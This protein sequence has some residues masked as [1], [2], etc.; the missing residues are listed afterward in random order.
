VRRALLPGLL[1]VV[2]AGCGTTANLHLPEDV[3]VSGPPRMGV[4]GGVSNSVAAAK[5][6]ASRD[7]LRPKCLAALA[8]LDV[9]LSAIGDTLTLPLTAT[10]TAWRLY[11]ES[12]PKPTPPPANDTPEPLTPERIHG[13]II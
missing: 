12:R 6:G 13:G 9:P 5:T 4:Y 1:A 3:F 8:A 10:V 11:E 7:G 2:L